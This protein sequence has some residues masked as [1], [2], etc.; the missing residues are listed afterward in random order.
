VEQYRDVLAP[1]SGESIRSLI[2]ERIG[3]GDPPPDA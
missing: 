2:N 3:D 1:Y